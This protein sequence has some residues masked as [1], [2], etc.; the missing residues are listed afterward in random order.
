MI[1][2]TSLTTIVDLLNWTV[3]RDKTVFVS[4]EIS[5]WWAIQFSNN[6]ICEARQLPVG[7]IADHN[8]HLLENFY[9]KNYDWRFQSAWIC[10]VNSYVC[11]L[12]FECALSKN[13]RTESRPV[14]KISLCG[15]SNFNMGLPN[16]W[17]IGLAHVAWILSA[18]V[19]S[20]LYN[21]TDYI[22][23]I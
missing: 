16:I 22:F 7:V 3:M 2:K 19:L 9:M 5:V 12:R 10:K 21:F 6:S 20:Y 1:L 17:R 18:L 8:E 11:T 13:P 14:W 15:G 23:E 4:I